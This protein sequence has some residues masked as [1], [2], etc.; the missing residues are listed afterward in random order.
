MGWDADYDDPASFL[1]VLSQGNNQNDPAYNSGLFNKLMEQG[2]VEAQP[3]R[4]LVLLR[5]AEQVLLD[6]YP[7]IP[8]YFSRGRRMV[9]PYVG[10]AKMTPMNRTYSKNLFWMGR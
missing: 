8:I 9:K 6:D 10:G 5:K 3:E 2:R 7:I 4:R 1:E